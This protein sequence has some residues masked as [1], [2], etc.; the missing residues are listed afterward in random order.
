LGETLPLPMAVEWLLHWTLRTFSWSAPAW[1][2]SRLR[3]LLLLCLLDALALRF[4]SLNATFPSTAAIAI[5]A[6]I[7]ALAIVSDS[8]VESQ[9]KASIMI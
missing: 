2:L 7:V 8:T 5:R 6:A 4:A 3:S 1:T 9:V